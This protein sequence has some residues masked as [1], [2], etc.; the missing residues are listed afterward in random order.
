[1]M[2]DPWVLAQPVLFAKDESEDARQG[3]SLNQF[4]FHH[5]SGLS[6]RYFSRKK[7]GKKISVDVSRLSMLPS[8]MDHF[9]NHPGAH[10]TVV[11]MMQSRAR[12]LKLEKEPLYR[13]VCSVV[14]GPRPRGFWLNS[15][16]SS[17][18]TQ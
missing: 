2:D 4:L 14:R 10:K 5:F 8:F 11:F 9:N 3:S 6:R 12:N 15:E 16:M 1:M 13:Q 7:K 18:P 17:R